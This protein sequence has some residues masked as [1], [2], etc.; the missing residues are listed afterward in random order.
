MSGSSVHT[1]NPVLGPRLPYRSR[2]AWVLGIASTL[3]AADVY[4]PVSPG[5]SWQLH[6]SQ[7]NMAP[8]TLPAYLPYDMAPFSR[9]R[10]RLALTQKIVVGS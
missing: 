4:T 9:K 6:T 5:D 10:E 3:G 7:C 1:L 8:E 2:K